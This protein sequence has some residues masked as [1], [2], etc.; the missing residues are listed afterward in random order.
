MPFWSMRRPSVAVADRRHRPAGRAR[1]LY[2]FGVALARA[3][4]V[5]VRCDSGVGCHDHR[6]GMVARSSVHWIPLERLRLC[7]DA[8]LALAQ[9][10]SVFGIWG[11]TFIAVVVFAT[12]GDA[13]T[14]DRAETRRTWLPLTL[15]LVVLAALPASARGGS[16]ARRRAWSMACICASCSRTC[17][18]TLVSITPPKTAGD[19][20][21]RCVVRS[22]R[23]P[24]IARDRTMR[25]I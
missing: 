21:L 9:A 17:S 1:H 18:R 5:R 8:P 2:A 14:D 25:R 19:G 13:L 24:A 7:A 12:P 15:G 6:S 23:R 11:L 20:A 4:W 10:A 22:R 3:L 16:R